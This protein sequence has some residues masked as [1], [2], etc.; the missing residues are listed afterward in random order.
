MKVNFIQ[1]NLK[2]VKRR[3][4]SIRSQSEYH[5]NMHHKLNSYTYMKFANLTADK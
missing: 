2:V 1:T 5:I 4:L 3:I